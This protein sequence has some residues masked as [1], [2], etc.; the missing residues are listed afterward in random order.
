[1]SNIDYDG[2]TWDEIR[3]MTDAELSEALQTEIYGD[4][5][6]TFEDIHLVLAERDRY[7]TMKEI[8]NLVV[9][10]AI[11]FVVIAL[12]TCVVALSVLGILEGGTYLTI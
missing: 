5:P 7:R 3:N 6:A 9:V 1:M 10:I 8:R 12:S 2:I 11:C 4:Q